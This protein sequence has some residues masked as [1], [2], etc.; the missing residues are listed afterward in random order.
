M[1]KRVRDKVM[2]LGNDLS[3]TRVDD[4]KLVRILA[5]VDRVVMNG[6]RVVM[7]GD[8][9]EGV[10]NVRRRSHYTEGR[11][12]ERTH[13]G[14]WRVNVRQSGKICSTNGVETSDQRIVAID[15]G[16][17][18]LVRLSVDER[19]HAVSDGERWRASV[20]Q[21]DKTCETG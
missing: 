17:R 9:R 11:R 5:V 7:N 21:D 20:R 4:N 3:K 10:L 14:S 19:V 2:S 8:S 12:R 1:E 13:R 18:R 16:R 15:Y 6:D